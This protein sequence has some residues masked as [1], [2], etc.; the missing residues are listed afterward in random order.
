MPIDDPQAVKFCNE[1][2][3]VMADLIEAMDRTCTQFMLNVVR[4]FEQV[5]QVQAAGDSDAI[6][7][8][9]AAD[10]RPGVTKAHIA[11]LKFVVEQLQAC[12]G[13]D[14]RRTLVH[15]WVV[16]AAPKF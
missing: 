3:R 7:D 8:G 16:N 15:N 4:D 6:V 13:T 11:Q 5:A 1:N 10:G 14:D 9:S 12:L 2:A